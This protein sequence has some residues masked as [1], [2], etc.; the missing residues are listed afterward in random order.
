MKWNPNTL[1]W[2]GN[3]HVLRD[4]DSAVGSSARPALITH[5]TGSSIGSPV[6]SF[7]SGARIV[8]NMVFDP[9]RMCWISTL[10]PDEDEPDVFANLADDEEDGEAW[11]TKGGTIRASL[12]LASSDASANT[13]STGANSS[14][15]SDAG[16]EAPSPAH[17]HSRTISESGS[18]R[19]S[20]ASIVC[21]VDEGFLDSCRLAEERHRLELKGWKSAL[22]QDIFTGPDRSYLYE[23]RALATRKY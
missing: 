16:Q 22:K 8:G 17:S 4:F 14:T 3:D 18:D 12:Q 1:R 10:P 13:T 11:E 6:G 15:S 7:A 5:L 21:D 19:G 23:I 2:E 9:T 20:R